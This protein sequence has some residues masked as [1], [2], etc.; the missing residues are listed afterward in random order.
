MAMTTM[1][2]EEELAF[3]YYVCAKY[4]HV[5]ERSDEQRKKVQVKRSWI[6]STCASPY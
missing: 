1:R 5:R 2:D 4:E 3:V 6:E